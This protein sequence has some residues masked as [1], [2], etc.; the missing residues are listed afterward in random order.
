[1]AKVKPLTL[2]SE[3]SSP[4]PVMIDD[5]P[6]VD[7]LVHLPY[8]ST[9]EVYTYFL[10]RGCEGADIGQLV[11]VTFA[12]H[13]ID[14]LLVRR[15][16]QK[17]DHGPIKPITMVISEVRIFSDQQIALAQELAKRYVSSTWS[18][19]SCL[20]YTSPSPRD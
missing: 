5:R 9:E 4:R 12:N 2:K 1:M 6:Y 16:A 7:V 20:L 15:F 3:K 13:E 14:G 11:A 17:P 10:P 8:L 18:F 19:L